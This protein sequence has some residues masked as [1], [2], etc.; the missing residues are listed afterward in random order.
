MC[1]TAPLLVLPLIAVFL[2][3]RRL[4]PTLASLIVLVAGA[5]LAVGL[6][7]VK[8]MPPLGLSRPELVM[9]AWDLATLIGLGV[10]LYLVTMAS[11]NLPGFAV[12]RASGYQPPTQPVLRRHRRGLARDRLPGR[13]YLQSRGDL[14]GALHRARGPSRSGAALEGG[15]LLRRVVGADR[16]V[17][18]LAGRI[19]RGRCRRPCWPPLRARRCWARW[20]GAMGAALAADE[21]RFAAAGTLAVTASGVTLMG[22]GSAF[23]GLCF[24]LLVLGV[25]RAVR[26]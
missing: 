26:R 4:V 17:R 18:R 10:P 25:E 7:L 22:V 11:Q 20:R 23:W 21:E 9:P 13:P 3:A 12:L 6:G 16:A 19:V 24:G 14:G 5:L 2:V 1:P 8:P 15:H